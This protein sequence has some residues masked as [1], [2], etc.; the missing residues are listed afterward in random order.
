MKPIE[1]VLVVGAGTMGHGFCQ[2]FALNGITV[3]LVDK[4]R[5]LLDQARGWI[6]DNLEYMAELKE[7]ADQPVSNILNHSQIM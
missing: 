3:T 4:N 7:L 2:I 5:D 6:Q 1:T